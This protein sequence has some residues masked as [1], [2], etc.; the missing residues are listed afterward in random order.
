MPVSQPGASLCHRVPMGNQ[1]VEQSQ[2]EPHLL[3]GLAVGGFPVCPPLVFAPWASAGAAST[4][5]HTHGGT[6][7]C[8]HS[9]IHIG[10][11]MHMSTH[12]QPQ[13]HKHT[14]TSSCPHTDPA[15]TSSPSTCGSRPHRMSSGF[16]GQGGGQ[17]RSLLV[18]TY[19]L[20]SVTGS[21]APV[22][23]RL[24]SQLFLGDL[25]S[26]LVCI[27]GS[28]SFLCGIL[29]IPVL[30]PTWQAYL[31][32]TIPPVFLLFLILREGLVYSLMYSYN[33]LECPTFPFIVGLSVWTTILSF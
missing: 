22:W 31:Y 6:H 29:G 26:L 28:T 4:H 10:T 33:D 1:W 2:Q 5:M 24:V 13:P 9:Y 27:S 12:P 32:W 30:M 3:F 17:V 8:M 14:I 25:L 11:H 7:V 15:F 18:S 23:A 16:G 19:V 21:R 20:R